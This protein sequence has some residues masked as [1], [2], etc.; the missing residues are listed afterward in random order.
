MIHPELKSLRQFAGIV[1][2]KATE[3]VKTDNSGKVAY[4]AN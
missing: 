3:V 2:A 1:P 4:T